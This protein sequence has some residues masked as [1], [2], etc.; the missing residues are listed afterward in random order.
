M[1]LL[2][3]SNFQCV[4][5]IEEYH[6]FILEIL[7]SQKNQKF[8]TLNLANEGGVV[9][10]PMVWPENLAKLDRLMNKVFS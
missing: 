2:H 9:N 1:F 10:G 4:G 8:Q 3:K 5:S 6:S 7:S